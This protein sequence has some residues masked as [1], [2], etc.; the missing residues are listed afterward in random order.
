MES[1]FPG[2][3]IFWVQCF[4]Q[5]FCKWWGFFFPLQG[6]EGFFFAIYKRQALLYFQALEKSQVSCENSMWSP[7]AYFERKKSRMRC[8]SSQHDWYFT[9]RVKFIHPN[10]HSFLKTDWFLFHYWENLFASFFPE[11]ITSYFELV[12]NLQIWGMNRKLGSSLWWWE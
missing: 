7:K 8:N 6:G 4:L 3:L 11:G 2:T 12:G 9:K 10:M 1:L 5:R